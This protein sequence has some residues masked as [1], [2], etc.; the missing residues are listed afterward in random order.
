MSRAFLRFICRGLRGV[1]NGYLNT[2]PAMLVGDLRTYYTETC[3]T[4]EASPVPIEAY[5]K[6]LSSIEKAVKHAYEGAGFGDAERPGPEKELLVNSRI[7]PVLVTAATTLLRQTVPTTNAEIDRKDIVLGD[8]AWLGFGDD[9]R[10]AMYRRQRDVDILKKFPLRPP[11][12]VGGS[13][14]VVQPQKKRRCVRCGEV[15]GE[16]TMPRSL[17][18]FRL[19]AK[20]GVVRSCPCGGMWVFEAEGLGSTSAIGGVSQSS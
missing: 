9:A 20:L 12:A 18:Y 17:P 2:N 11:L 4:I 6:F 15:T 16:V 1:H 8:Y 5:E 19:L 13:G 3:Q 14:R 7:P 10:T